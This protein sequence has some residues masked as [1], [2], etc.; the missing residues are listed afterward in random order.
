VSP[1]ASRKKEGVVGKSE[2]K[3][4]VLGSS[5]LPTVGENHRAAK[6]TSMERSLLLKSRMRERKP[7]RK[8]IQSIG[9]LT[10]PSV[11]GGFA[12]LAQKKGRRERNA[13]NWGDKRIFSKGEQDPE[14]K[15][16]G[17]HL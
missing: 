1:T 14:S 8:K 7:E 6:K 12:K 4:V 5:I 11:N 16:G 13:P 9:G 17:V 10:V 3:V 2:K 15:A